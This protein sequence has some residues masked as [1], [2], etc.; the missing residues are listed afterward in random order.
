MNK[1]IF[2]TPILGITLAVILIAGLIQIPFAFSY[3]PYEERPLY[4]GRDLS[5]QR[6]GYELYDQNG[7]LQ[8]ILEHYPVDAFEHQFYDANTH[9][10]KPDVLNLASSLGYDHEKPIIDWDSKIGAGIQRDIHFVK[11][12][13]SQTMILEEINNLQYKLKLKFVG[14]SVY[15]PN[16]ITVLSST[17]SLES[18]IDKLPTHIQKNFLSFLKDEETT[19]LVPINRIPDL[20]DLEN[21]DYVTMPIHNTIQADDISAPSTIPSELKYEPELFLSPK[22]QFKNGLLAFQIQCNEGLELIFKSSN[23]SPACVK[24]QTAEKLVERGWA[25]EN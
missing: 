4:V 11:L 21:L 20:E 7:D 3:D 17:S 12:F 25:N 1:I 23:G 14:E 8:F 6:D 24:P 18:K 2:A 16:Y 19:I 22:Q 15:F 9:T 13:L 5:I 10:I